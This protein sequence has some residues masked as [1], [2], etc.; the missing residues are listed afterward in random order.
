[1]PLG[2]LVMTLVLC[3]LLG[4]WRYEMVSPQS[5]AQAISHFISPYVVSVRG[6]V[7]DEP[8]VT[9]HSRALIVAVNDVS[10]DAG[11]TWYPVRGQLEVR[12]LGTLIEDPY[13]PNYGD[14]VQL[15]GKL[16]PPSPHSPVNVF[17]SM[18][19]PRVSIGEPATG[20]RII[21]ALYHFRIVLS[22]II[23][24]ALPQPE[25]ALLVALLL[26][27][28]TP[29]LKPLIP[30]FNATGVAHLVAPS[31]FKVTLLAGMVTNLA[32][33]LYRTEQQVGKRL[34]P[35]QRRGGWQRWLV[36]VVTVVIIL[37]YTVLNGV[38]P[39]AIRAGIMGILLIVAPRLGR[40]YNVYTGLALAVVLVSVVDPLVLWDAGFLLSTLGTLGIVLLTP[41]FQRLLSPLAHLPLGSHVVEI[42]AVTL[43]AQVA[44]LPISTVT[45][46]QI[47]F[48]API[49]NILTVPLLGA[50]IVLGACVC[51]AGL[52]YAPLARLCG[53][54]V[55]PLL[56]YVKSIVTWCFTLP[57]AYITTNNISSTVA[58]S[59]Y[60]VLALAVYGVSRIWP[61]HAKE[62][63]A[64]S[65]RMLPR[66]VW[67][68][69]QVGIALVFVIATGAGALT[70]QPN[71]H[72][73]ITFLAVGPAGQSLQGEAILVR[74]P[75]GKTLLI[76]GGSDAVSLSQ[77]LDSRLPSWQ[78]SLDAVVL[79]STRT[80]HL[81]G[82]QDVINRY[83]IGEVID[84]GMLHP[85][86]A[87]ALWRSLIRERHFP[88]MRAM[89]GMNISIGAQV[90][91]QV[92][93]PHASLSKGK[94]EERRNALVLRLVAPGARV[95]FLGEV[96][97][98]Q[99][100]LQ[101]I[102]SEVDS[103]HLRAEIVQVIGEVTTGFPT[104]L[105][106]VLRAVHPTLLIVTPPSKL[107]K[108]RV[109]AR[110]TSAALFEQTTWQTIYT[111]QT[112]TTTLSSSASGWSVDTT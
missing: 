101:G 5:D 7:V 94:D 102:L 27:L 47:S 20:T 79:T 6:T 11:V 9:E 52:L 15:Q 74:T 17:A 107:H 59:Y 29:P 85:S 10:G 98:S 13:G 76:D 87:Y 86:N 36:T 42:I 1:D 46:N 105:S 75:D 14:S 72:L 2:R 91:L 34:L 69:I 37:F 57:G 38:V 44:T 18:A 51:A 33:K 103:N 112:G 82:L 58:W 64:S 95:L 63:L 3:L 99:P 106:E 90:V 66:Y 23:A 88:Y 40:V 68:S 12:L 67:Q 55:E 84:G 22:T 109:L 19:F 89:Q 8:K 30:A 28:R 43:A 70:L 54:V 26:S 97:N 31:G 56:W 62:H 53:W 16:Q 108:G 49:T 83:D 48:I 25:A 93:W 65:T 24:R 60:A 77:A 80:D 78:R 21:A 111:V 61:Q 35:A 39:A 4:A 100:A 32:R 71:G 41:F 104:E 96:A 81:A 45:F 50:F 110:D 92:L 73:S